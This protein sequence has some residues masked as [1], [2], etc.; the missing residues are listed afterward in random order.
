MKQVAAAIAFKEDRVLV[1]RRA[2]GQKLA[3]FWEFPGGKL[4]P[5]E[6]ASVCIVR[7]LEEELGVQSAAGDVIVESVHDYP[8]GSINLIAIEVQLFADR[9]H[10]SV[11]DAAEFVS[12]SELLSMQ[13]APADMPIA[14][15]LIRL[16]ATRSK[17]A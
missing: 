10:L 6:T 8:G 2:P 5:G 13:L 1:T 7:E 14:E 17:A 4:E 16:T 9:F 11:H 3:G 12:P 15:E